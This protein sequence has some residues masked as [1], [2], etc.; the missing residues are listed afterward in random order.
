MTCDCKLYIPIIIDKQPTVENLIFRYSTLYKSLPV[1]LKRLFRYFFYCKNTR[2]VVFLKQHLSHDK[3]YHL[4][5]YCSIY[6]YVI[7]NRYVKMI[8]IDSYA[9]RLF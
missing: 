2:Y 3:D 1:C 7:L 4:N 9:C 8:V 5:C 6:N